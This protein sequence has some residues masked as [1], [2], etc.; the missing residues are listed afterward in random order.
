[1]SKIDK[2]AFDYLLREFKWADESFQYAYRQAAHLNENFRP[3]ICDYVMQ[4]WSELS[5]ELGLP[6]LSGVVFEGCRGIGSH[7]KWEAKMFITRVS[8]K[9]YADDGK[10]YERSLTLENYNTFSRWDVCDAPASLDD[11][12]KVIDAVTADTGVKLELAIH[13]H[14]KDDSL[15]PQDDGATALTNDGDAADAA[16]DV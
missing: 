3:A 6:A 12:Q 7:G 2:K 14:A 8:S 5:T 16:P 13:K 10:W 15:S 1:M 11:I 4:R 9:L